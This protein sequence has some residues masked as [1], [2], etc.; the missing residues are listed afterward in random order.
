MNSTALY[1]LSL[2]L[3]I[4]GIIFTLD[5]PGI[6]KNLVKS[7]KKSTKVKKTIS[8]T[9][10]YYQG[11]KGFY[12]VE[13]INGARAILNETGR[14][15]EFT[16]TTI[17]CVVMT[18]AGALLGAAMQ[19]IIAAVAL[20]A[21]FFMIP[22][23]KL[24]LYKNKYRRYLNAQLESCTSL[25]TT[26]YIRN[27]DICKAVEEN[28]NQLSPLV[29]PYFEDFLAESKVNPGLKNCIR[30]LRDKINE[31]IFKEWCETLIRTIDNTEMKETLLP[32]ANKYSVV[33]VVQDDLDTETYGALIEYIIMAAMCILA[34]PL[35]FL[36]NRDWFSYYRTIAGHFVVGYTI[37][38]LFFSIIRFISVLTPVE[39]K[40]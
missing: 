35:V 14:G 15:A 37:I 12:V 1:F 2:G 26:T 7:R 27:N 20:G 17:T 18:A 38:V 8:D 3:F 23:W 13:E 21:M 34:Y 33:K 31:P 28:I 24:K 29:K 5:F 36:L 25:I 40:R 30:N 39:Y 32:V 11:K 22:L 9:I 4:L 6:I 19:S 16:K 10:D